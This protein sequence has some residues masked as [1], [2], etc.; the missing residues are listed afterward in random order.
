MRIFITSLIVPI[1]T[2]LLF[3]ASSAAECQ[4]SQNLPSQQFFVAFPHNS[5]EI[6]ESEQVRIGR[7]VSAMN[8]DYP[9]QNW[10]TIIGSAS[11]L[12]ADSE[13]LAT[14][15][16]SATAKVVIDDGLINAPFQIKTQIYPANHTTESTPE[17][18]EVTIQVSPGCLDNCCTGH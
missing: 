13:R 4:G 18:R 10:I 1:V 9:I 15:R 6:S 2:S 7:W 14:K 5:H 16:A 8:S 11:K 17:T 12:E 3:P